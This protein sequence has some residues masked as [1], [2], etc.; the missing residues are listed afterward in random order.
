M[1]ETEVLTPGRPVGAADDEG[2]LANLADNLPGGMV[3]QLVAQGS[4]RRFVYVSKGVTQLFGVDP[5]QAL[6]D[7]QTLYGCILPDYFPELA[8]RETAAIEALSPFFIEV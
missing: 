5:A 1:A 7:A 3:F 4:T 2:R 8:Q 6:G